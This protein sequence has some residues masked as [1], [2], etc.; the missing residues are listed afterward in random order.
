MIEYSDKSIFVSDAEALVN[1]VN[2]VGIAGKGLAFEFKRRFPSSF[3]GYKQWC[4]E[5]RMYPGFVFIHVYENGEPYILSF[6]TKVHWKHQSHYHIIEC[7]LSHLVERV[8]QF[9][10]KSI[11]IP[12]LG[13]GLGGL[14]WK[15]VEPLIIEAFKELPDVRVILHARTVPTL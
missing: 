15:D 12:M 6:P 13:C 9:R 14:D 1:P 4:D 8:K 11:S 7:G 5:G 3:K 10:I 2:C